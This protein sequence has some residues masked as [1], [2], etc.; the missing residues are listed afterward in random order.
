VN[1][2][3]YLNNSVHRWKTGNMLFALYQNDKLLKIKKA[4]C[5]EALGNF[6]LVC[7]KLQNKTYTAFARGHDLHN[8][9]PIIDIE[10]AAQRTR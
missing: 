6:A 5:Y 2:T 4:V 10:R 3:I 7:F 8:G 9:L 1:T